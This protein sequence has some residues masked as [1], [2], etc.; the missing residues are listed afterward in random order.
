[1]ALSLRVRVEAGGA[2]L[3]RR[4]ANPGCIRTFAAIVG[5]QG[6]GTAGKLYC[7]F[8]CQQA[9]YRRRVRERKEC[10]RDGTGKA[11][12]AK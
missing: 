2:I 9:A 8:E 6:G 12:A 1:M 11:C 5:P 3:T 4:C 10:P 7:C